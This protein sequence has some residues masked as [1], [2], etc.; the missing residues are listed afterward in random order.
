MEF[1]TEIRGLEATPLSASESLR[2]Y[3]PTR[4][5]KSLL[6]ETA[7]N[8]YHQKY[9]LIFQEPYDKTS[10][11]YLK[12]YAAD[13]LKE[14]ADNLTL[15]DE[16]YEAAEL[17]ESQCLENLETARNA[18]TNAENALKIYYKNLPWWSR[19]L[20][21]GFHAQDRE[22]L[23]R[24]LNYISCRNS[25]E[26]ATQNYDKAWD[27]SILKG[28]EYNDCEAEYSRCV[29]A[30]TEIG[31]CWDS[32]DPSRR[33]YACGK[34]VIK[35]V[36]LTG[37]VHPESGKWFTIDG[38]CTKCHS[39]LKTCG[40]SV[41]ETSN[42]ISDIIWY[43]CDCFKP[44]A[45]LASKVL[46]IYSKNLEFIFTEKY[47]KLTGG[48]QFPSD[49][50]ETLEIWASHSP[51]SREQARN[52]IY[53]AR[54]LGWRIV[55]PGIMAHP[56]PEQA[57]KV[58]CHAVTGIHNLSS[59]CSIYTVLKP[60][61]FRE[62]KPQYR[63]VLTE[64]TEILADKKYYR[65]LYG[66]AAACAADIAAE[67][68]ERNYRI[69]FNRAVY[70]L[71]IPY[72]DQL[73]TLVPV[74]IAENRRK[75]QVVMK[76]LKSQA[77]FSQ[78]TKELNSREVIRQQNLYKKQH[79]AVVFA[80]AKYARKQRVFTKFIKHAKGVKAAV[81]LQ[82]FQTQKRFSMV[83]KELLTYYY[84][85]R[86][87]SHKSTIIREIPILA[88]QTQESRYLKHASMVYR[89]AS[90]AALK[91]DV[92]K[93]TIPV[94][95]PE[96]PPDNNYETAWVDSMQELATSLLG[97]PSTQKTLENSTVLVAD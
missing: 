38:K 86:G 81:K 42:G 2:K 24:S 93:L 16:A 70:L 59:N 50:P 8:S 57:V 40:Y 46:D 76:T 64:L 35:K 47:G 56:D 53:T 66:W 85:V 80:A 62:H 69:L 95:E 20:P 79:T 48:Y 45:K 29:D 87:M 43:V 77:L 7:V 11:C 27:S 58:L 72:H 82:S 68:N 4:S 67:N 36:S 37:A 78:F 73:I 23:E 97:F 13:K 3:V 21:G 32:K 15:A 51:A 83:C 44:Q 26:K 41:G 28:N 49:D 12:G 91:R 19:W 22:F 55:S 34:T 63:L 54:R 90:L 5:L 1:I 94:V 61:Y 71:D 25:I 10:T 33:C 18:V 17:C 6:W 14:A 96:F 84:S 65:D 30:L 52:L 74:N 31:S 39:L 60:P 75:Y 92:D 9:I 89:Q 88:E